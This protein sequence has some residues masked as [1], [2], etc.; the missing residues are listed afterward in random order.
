MRL[1]SVGAGV[2]GAGVLTR[3]VRDGEFVDGEKECKAES[4]LV[5][6]MELPKGV[7]V[8]QGFRVFPKMD[9]TSRDG[10]R[11]LVLFPTMI[12][13]RKTKYPGLQG[14]NQLISNLQFDHL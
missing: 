10:K 12:I 4:P 13:T 1:I 3:S 8:D 11:I 9:Y 7:V 2:D 6:Q 5:D 14:R